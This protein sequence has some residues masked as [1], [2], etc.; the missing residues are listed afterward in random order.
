MLTVRTTRSTTRR[1]LYSPET[2]AP[3]ERRLK[4]RIVSMGIPPSREVCYT[5]TGLI[6]SDLLVECVRVTGVFEVVAVKEV[7]EA[8]SALAS[9]AWFAL[10]NFSLSYHAFG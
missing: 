3:A 10:I 8:I 6:T 7:K 4:R 2:S 9:S 5:L 1:E